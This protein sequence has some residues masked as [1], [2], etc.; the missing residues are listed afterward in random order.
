MA[1]RSGLLMQAFIVLAAMVADTTAFKIPCPAAGSIIPAASPQSNTPSLH[2]GRKT[3]QRLLDVLILAATE[4]SGN[5]E[6]D[7]NCCLP[8]TSNLVHV[9]RSGGSGASHVHPLL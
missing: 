4:Y 1:S 5:T 8:F 9:Q 3:R 6:G 2:T 7:K